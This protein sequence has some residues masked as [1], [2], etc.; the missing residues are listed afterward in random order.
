MTSNGEEFLSYRIALLVSYLVELVCD[1]HR[2][3]VEFLNLIIRHLEEWREHSSLET[4]PSGNTFKGVEG[5][6]N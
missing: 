1:A 3:V 6:L 4:A 2:L 5:S